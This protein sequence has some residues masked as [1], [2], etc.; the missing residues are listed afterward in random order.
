MKLKAWGMNSSL[1][2]KKGSVNIVDKF[3]K[4]C[5][6][7][8]SL[9]FNQ[10]HLSMIGYVLS[11]THRYTSV[12]VKNTSIFLPWTSPVHILLK[13]NTNRK[14]AMHSIL[15]CFKKSAFETG[16]AICESSHMV[17]KDKST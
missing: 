17:H 8:L 14:F 7:A 6:L 1:H 16:L 13:L 3:L 12:E 15:C 4:N 5:F 2:R 10:D 9:K 11:L